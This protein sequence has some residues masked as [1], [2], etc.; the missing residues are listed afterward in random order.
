M[1]IF[2]NGD[3]KKVLFSGLFSWPSHTIMIIQCC[4]LYYTG[5]WQEKDWYHNSGRWSTLY[6]TVLQKEQGRPGSASERQKE[7]RHSCQQTIGAAIPIL[8]SC[9]FS[10]RTNMKLGIRVSK[11]EGYNL[12]PACTLYL[13]CMRSPG[14]AFRKGLLG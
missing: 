13:T 1:E 11:S 3:S 8:I 6:N 14:A 4:C 5:F 10:C 9:A 7:N 12:T 2:K